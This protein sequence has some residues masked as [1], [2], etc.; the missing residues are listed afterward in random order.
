MCATFI[1]NAGKGYYIY[2]WLNSVTVGAIKRYSP[3][4]LVHFFVQ[5]KVEK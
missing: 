5:M 4:L 3:S 1:S 2:L